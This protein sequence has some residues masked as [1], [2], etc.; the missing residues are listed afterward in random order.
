MAPDG[1]IRLTALAAIAVAFFAASQDIVIDAYRI[2]SLRE[3]QQGAGAAVAVTGYRIG[4]FAAGAGALLLAYSLGWSA[5]YAVMALLILVG[6]ATVLV[7]PEPDHAENRGV[8]P[9]LTGLAA[10][11]A[12]TMST[13]NLERENLERANLARVNL[14]RAL[15]VAAAFGLLAGLLLGRSQ[16][17]ETGLIAGLLVGAPVAALL[18][19]FSRTAAIRE[20]AIEPFQDFFQRNGIQAA[21]A[22]L[23]FIS[24]FKASDVLLTLVANPFYI[25]L[26]FT[27]KDIGLVA[28]VFGFFVTFLGAY[29]A[30]LMIYRIGLLRSLMISGALMMASN[31]IFAAQ[32][33][34]GDNYALFHVTIMVENFSGGMGTTAFVAYLSSLCNRRYTAVQYALLTSFMQILG[35]FVIVPSSG[36]LVAGLG[37]I[38]FFILSAAAGLPALLLLWWLSRRIAIDAPEPRRAGAEPVL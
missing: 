10:S 25:E 38:A 28:G 17:V 3:D 7:S 26:G 34:A 15:G 35:K 37:W 24:L 18:I 6:V 20:G 27:E 4:M 13:A 23:A 19:L 30:G 29:F 11:T 14:A 31:L 21:L 16:G 2:E 12:S 9:P 1:S 5:A 33:M 8:S 22:I 32:A 36:F